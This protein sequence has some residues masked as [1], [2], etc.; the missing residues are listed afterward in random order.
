MPI[1]STYSDSLRVR[2]PKTT[3]SAAT[4]DHILGDTPKSQLMKSA[5]N[6]AVD[7]L[8]AARSD[9]SS[10]WDN[11]LE[12]DGAIGKPR[13]RKDGLE[14]KKAAGNSNVQENAITSQLHAPIRAYLA[15]RPL[16]DVARVMHLECH[17][18]AP[19]QSPNKAGDM[20]GKGDLRFAM[21]PM[22]NGSLD[23][24]FEAKVL[25]ST[26]DIKSAYLGKDGLQRF[27]RAED[28]YTEAPVGGLLA[29]VDVRSAKKRDSEISTALPEETTTLAV[30]H[31]PLGTPEVAERCSQHRREGRDEPIWMIH[32]LF[33]FPSMQVSAGP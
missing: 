4:L 10:R 9:L 12:R 16:G 11:F 2:Q 13:K 30:L 17:L 29:Y 24:V 25:R 18:Q 32:L 33:A 6:A 26:S 8:R 31:V 1:A 15:A 19:I 14:K 22:A 27:C 7:A 23:I 20:L 5:C 3:M 21:V 28:P